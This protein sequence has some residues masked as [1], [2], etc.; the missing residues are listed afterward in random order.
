MMGALM[1]MGSSAQ[2][3]STPQSA[4]PASDTLPT[5]APDPDRQSTAS[6]DPDE[7]RQ[8]GRAFDEVDTEKYRNLHRVVDPGRILKLDQRIELA[9]DAQRLTTHGLPTRVL[10]TE[11]TAS[12][13]ESQATADQL[14]VAHKV[15]SSKGAD[16]GMFMLVTVDPESPR[17]GTVVLSFGRNALPK[18]GLTVET[19]EDIYERTILPRLKRNRLYS[20]LHVG[21]RRMIYLET[22]IPDAPAPLTESQRTLRS[23]V[24]VL[25][26]LAFLGSAVGLVVSDRASTRS[27]VSRGRHPTMPAGRLAR[28]ALFAGLG[29]VLLFF[30]A[31]VGRSTIGVA[32]ALLVGLLVW[33]QLVIRGLP[34]QSAPPGTRMLSLPYRRGFMPIRQSSVR[35]IDTQAGNASRRRTR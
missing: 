7:S 5:P 9:D 28:T 29:A 2:Q 14:R 4:P 20:A 8:I 13:E 18:G 23:A 26:P 35:R 25:G 22:Y 27:R 3:V 10:L 24:N 12:R 11:G 19:V 17:S 33:T 1:P 6:G 31:V 30:A 21:I 16:D 34:R 15:E 32:S